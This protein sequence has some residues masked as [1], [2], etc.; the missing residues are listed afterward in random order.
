LEISTWF[1]NIESK[2]TRTQRSI[3]V[4]SPKQLRWVFYSLIK[5]QICYRNVNIIL[6][7]K[8]ESTVC[9]IYMFWMIWIVL[10]ILKYRNNVYENCCM[11]E[12]CYLNW[13]K[14]FDC[15]LRLWFKFMYLMPAAF[16]NW[17]YAK[18]FEEII[19]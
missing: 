15:L 8:S 10:I 2:V 9:W 17:N 7:Y 4:M 19:C 5:L 14:V 12:K 13:F 1:S 18:L 16:G 11:K 6:F 3:Q